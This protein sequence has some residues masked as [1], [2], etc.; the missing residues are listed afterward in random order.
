MGTEAGKNIALFCASVTSRKIR[1]LRTGQVNVHVSSMLFS[2]S[3]HEGT[4][5]ASNALWAQLGSGNLL[6]ATAVTFILMLL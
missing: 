4:F 6:A 5:Q 2:V 1:N 3:L